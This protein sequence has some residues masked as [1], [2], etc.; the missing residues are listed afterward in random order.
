MAL[1]K[2]KRTV[3]QP[4]NTREESP[5]VYYRTGDVRMISQ[6]DIDFVKSA[7]DS[8]PRRRARLCLH[9]D[10]DAAVHEMLIAHHASVYVRPHAHGN[11]DESFQV[12]EGRVRALIFDPDGN[13]E[14]VIPLT[15]PGQPGTT[16]PYYYR[17]P[18]MTYH[19]L[20][21]DSE[22]LL[23]HEVAAGP[24]NP[25]TTVFPNWAPDGADDLSALA[26]LKERA[27][28]VLS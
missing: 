8:N 7:A 3:R 10:T 16:S 4:Q 20:L 28:E 9:H 25:E 19:S 13:V 21:I 23:F 18:R 11:G 14:Q 27:G 15:S 22:W 2:I 24:F 1:D 26:W 5:E 17:L 6:E 12:L